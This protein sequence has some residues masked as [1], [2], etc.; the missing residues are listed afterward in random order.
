GHV[1]VRGPVDD[2]VVDDARSAPASPRRHADE[3]GTP[4]PRDHRLA[5]AERRPVERAT[6]GHHHAAPEED[7]E[8]RGVRGANDN[9]PRGP[10]PVVADKNPA[11]VVIGCPTPR[12]IIEPGPSEAWVPD[13]AARAVRHPAP[14]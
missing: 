2:D 11:A 14:G 4:P 10:R 13:P 3:A 1:D 8:R 12:R 6:R 5:P 7:N 9:G